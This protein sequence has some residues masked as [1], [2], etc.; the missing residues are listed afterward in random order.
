[1]LYYVDE[2]QLPQSIR[3]I[4]GREYNDTIASWIP[5]VEKEGILKIAEVWRGMVKNEFPENVETFGNIPYRLIERGLDNIVSLV[6]NSQEINQVR[7]GIIKEIISEV[8]RVK[9]REEGE[10]GTTPVTSSTYDRGSEVVIIA[11]AKRESESGGFV[12]ELWGVSDRYNRQPNN[13]TFQV[14]SCV[15]AG[16]IRHEAG[17]GNRRDAGGERQENYRIDLETYNWLKEV[18]NQSFNSEASRELVAYL[19]QYYVPF[20]RENA[21]L[22]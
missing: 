6:R 8:R 1:V 17:W 2:N 3:S 15:T 22:G 4:R 18:F 19:E 11:L 20:M 7:R 9:R 16:T 5:Y 13:D 21:G 10:G 12:S 14:A